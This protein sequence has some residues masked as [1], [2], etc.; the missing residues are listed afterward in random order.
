MK[1]TSLFL[2]FG[3]FLFGVTLAQEAQIAK[4]KWYK[5]HFG[6]SFTTISPLR[7]FPNLDKRYLPDEQ[8]SWGFDYIYQ[9]HPRASIET[10]LQLYGTYTE[11]TYELFEQSID[12]VDA[13]VAIHAPFRARF[14]WLN[15]KN[16]TLS[17]FGA[18]ISEINAEKVYLDLFGFG[19]GFKYNF[20]HK[21]NA[22]LDLFALARTS[23]FYEK[24]IWNPSIRFGITVAL[25]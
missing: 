4:K 21:M 1:K 11:F 15:H 9:Y 16:L 19:Q 13:Y 2:F 23:K 6:S 18:A 25:D 7:L 20:L 17:F 14:N 5:H 22:N 24:T 12:V 10:G 8:G 3:L